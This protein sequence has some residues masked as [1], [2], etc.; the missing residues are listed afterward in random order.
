MARILLGWELGAN[1]GHAIR[2]AMLGRTLR[3][4]G[5][6][7]A[8]A[9][10]R[11][12]TMRGHDVGGATIWQAPLSSRLLAG[13]ARVTKVPAGMADILARIGM[14]DSGVVASVVAAWRQLFTAARPDLVIADFAPFLLLAARDRI[15]SVSVG[16]G[17]SSPP[18]H[19][20]TL[21][22]LLQDVAGVDQWALVAM[23]N[24]ALAELG[25]PPI[26]ALP[27]V[28]AADRSIVATFAELDP[29]AGDR[30]TALAYPDTTDPDVEAGEGEE[31]FVYFTDMLGAD[32]PLWQ[33]LA[34]SGLKVRVHIGLG[35]EKARA[36]IA[37]HGFAVEP[38][39]LPFRQIAARSRLLLSHGG[40]GFT[41]DGLAAGLPHVI[42]HYDLEKWSHGLALARAGLGGHVALRSIQP[43][44]FADSLVRVFHDDALAARVRAAAPGFR[45]RPQ[46]PLPQAI[47]EAV[48]ELV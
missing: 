17:F 8:F 39:P 33:G 21:P 48:A 7:I 13:A 2:L 29:Y 6:D 31:V 44:A 4:A 14:D 23:V 40:H 18:A 37:A 35:D 20:T 27:E 25:D 22:P 38:R 15:P 3:E 16:T 12:D 26:A 10:S 1:R 46:P 9:V 41:C 45:S 47:A 36:G 42:C 32:S 11:L 34:M 28:F 5:H 24:T 43:R 19:M 30:G